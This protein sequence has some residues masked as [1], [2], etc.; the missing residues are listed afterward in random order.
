MRTPTTEQKAA[1]AERRAK[2]KAICDQ[3]AALPEN[4]RI[5]LGNQCL[6]TNVEGHTL[7]PFNQCLI[8]YQFASATIVGGFHQWRKAG[9]MV[10]KGEHCI[11]IWVPIGKKDAKTAATT[12]TTERPGF[13]LGA[14]FDVSQTEPM[15]QES[16]K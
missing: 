1:A 4:E 9:R 10:K 2:T 8:A 15:T 14:I 12:E 3:I 6:A 16:V 5:A 13:M 11:S 7:S